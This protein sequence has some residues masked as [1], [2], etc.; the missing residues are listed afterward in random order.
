MKTY[1]LNDKWEYFRDRGIS[2]S[3]TIL[4]IEIEMRI[5]NLIAVIVNKFT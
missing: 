4:E 2:R 3:G 1:K 5:W